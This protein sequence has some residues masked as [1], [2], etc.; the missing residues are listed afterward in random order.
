MRIGFS[1]GMIYYSALSLCGFTI[2]WFN[3]LRLCSGG[4]IGR[5]RELDVLQLL[6]TDLVVDVLVLNGFPLQ[7]V[8]DVRGN[9]HGL[10]LVLLLLC[11]LLGL[12]LCCLDGLLLLCL[13]VGI[14]TALLLYLVQLALVKSYS[15]HLDVIN[16]P[17][18]SVSVFI[19]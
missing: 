14:V 16:R 4:L 5:P 7:Q 2:F 9:L 8:L 15:C 13:S 17:Q 18:K 10:L 3:W 12:L 19:G 6:L 11:L 1:H